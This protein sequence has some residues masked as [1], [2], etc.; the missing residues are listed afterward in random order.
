MA[1]DAYLSQYSSIDTHLFQVP[2][3]Q[4]SRPGMGQEEEKKRKYDTSLEPHGQFMWHRYRLLKLYAMNG[5][6]GIPS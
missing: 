4:T 1:T 5:V 2:L 3:Q 6:K